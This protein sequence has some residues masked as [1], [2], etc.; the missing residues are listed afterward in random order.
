MHTVGG[1]LEVVQVRDEQW[2]VLGGRQIIRKHPESI[3]KWSGV[4]Y[5]PSLPLFAT[6]LRH[7]RAG[8]SNISG[9]LRLR[10]AIS[11]G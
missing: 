8:Q 10:I 7:H 5:P 4:E 1:V 9:Y 11:H 6:H 2:V 3:V